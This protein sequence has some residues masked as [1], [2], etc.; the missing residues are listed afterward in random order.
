MHYFA[1][2]VTTLP[3]V[4]DL[5]VSL[6]A[7]FCPRFTCL[8]VPLPSVQGLPVSSLHSLLF[9][10]Y[11]FHLRTAFCSRLTCFT[12]PLPSV[13]DLPVFIIPLPSVQ[14]LPVSSLH[15]LLSKIYLFHLSTTFCS[16]FTR[17]ISPLPTV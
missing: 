15:Y 13:Q 10:V 1:L 7:T 3:T 17:F 11:L 4:L 6:S 8:I 12:S 5:P 14:D 9:K 2:E 16:R